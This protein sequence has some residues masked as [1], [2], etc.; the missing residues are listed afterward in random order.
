MRGRLGPGMTEALLFVQ[1]NADLASL[2]PVKV[3]SLGSGWKNYIPSRPALPKDYF[4]LASN[5]LEELLSD[6]ETGG[7]DDEDG[8]DSSDEEDEESIGSSSGKED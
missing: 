2:D 1:R 8:M 7:G 6:E 3:E 5:E 4:A